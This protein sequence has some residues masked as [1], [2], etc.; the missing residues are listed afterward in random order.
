MSGSRRPVAMVTG[1]GRNIGRSIALELANWGADVI[2]VVRHRREEAEQVAGEIRAL[3]RDARAVVAD[4]RDRRAI[5]AAVDD[6]HTLGSPTI[7]VNNAAT[8]PEA[9][10]LELTAEDWR[11]VTSVILDGAFVCAQAMIPSMLEAGWGR[12]VNIAGVTGQTG[13]SNRA[14]VVAA[15]AGLLGLTKAL[16]MEYAASNITVNAVSPGLIDT[17]RPQGIPR[18]H[19]GRTAPVGRMGRVEEVAA[20]VRYLVSAEAAYVTGQTLNVNG[21]LLT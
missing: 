17:S 9:P 19:A 7:L 3:G 18:H 21:G 16:A 20:I 2:V 14:H 13:A 1:A 8:R 10:F 4:I 6:A 15:K 5:A 11:E 12:I